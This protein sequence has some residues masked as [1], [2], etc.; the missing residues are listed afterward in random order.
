MIEH[1]VTNHNNTC[2][3]H[4]VLDKENKLFLSFFLLL[5]KQK[6]D[7]IYSMGLKSEVIK[8]REVI[9]KTL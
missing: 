1:I 3:S 6:P 8:A 7:R 5:D 4:D 2:Q 9:S